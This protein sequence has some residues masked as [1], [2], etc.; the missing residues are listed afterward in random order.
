VTSGPEFEEV[1]LKY[2]VTD[3]AALRGRLDDGL[4]EDVR[5][6]P[7]RTR[8][9]EDRYFDTVDG[10]LARAGFGARLR[11]IDGETLV[12]VKSAGGADGA[13]GSG[14]TVV[15]ALHRRSEQEA[16][17]SSHL[18]ASEW[19]ASDARAVIQ[20]ICGDAPLVTRYELR[21]RRHERS[22]EREGER[23][24]LSLDEVRV[25]RGRTTVGSFD[26]LEIEADGE[27]TGLLAHVA[28]TL[29]PTGLVQ[30]EART[31]EEIARSMVGSASPS[32]TRRL[33]KVQ[34]SPGLTADDTLAEA[35]RKV[36]AFHLSRML[37]REAGT[38]TGQDIEDVHTMRVATRR[39]RAAW[40]TFAGA[41]RPREERRYVAE[42]RDVAG[43]LGAVRDLDVLLDG[44]HGY[45]GALG[46]ERA[47]A[48]QPLIDEWRRRREAAQVKLTKLLDSDTYGRFVDDYVAFVTTPGAGTAVVADH[49]PVRVR[50]TAAG[51]IWQAY[52]H[53]RAY[54][55]T[56]AWADMATLHALRI[57]GKRLR[58]ALEF[59]REALPDR[60]DDL[61]ARVTAMQDHLGALN[62]ANVAAALTREWLVATGARLPDGSR[63]EIGA[64]LVSRERE[65]VRLRR[66]F[67]P[68]W[69]R[70]AGPAF[71][72]GLARTVSEL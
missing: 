10:A 53:V 7:W 71:R 46:E 60:V 37:A 69:R 19:P 16:P 22:L 9:I 43:A 67:G 59:F 6:G 5:T 57:E 31:K 52:E 72:R 34:K 20:R 30:P 4:L 41:Y 40:R 45:V 39:M 63:R 33:P 54:D 64:Y 25:R 56:L 27:A 12:T 23:A 8:R 51:R 55:P 2:A 18:R 36:L 11:R 58:Y 50:E 3:P 21:Q 32:P 44:I 62:D 28:A 15:G 48:M 38:R 1:E 61:I 68:V 42:L 49:A 17:A 35:C 66:T 29:E 70:V 47:P 13:A 65:A 26:A 14:S 24:T